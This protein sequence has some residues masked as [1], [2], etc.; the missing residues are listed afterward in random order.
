MTTCQDN[1][2]R[3]WDCWSN[4]NLDKLDREIVHSHNF[5]RYMTPFR[6]DRDLKDSTERLAIIGR[7]IYEDFSGVPLHPV[8]L[9]DTGTGGSVAELLDP[10]LTTI[11]P[12]NKIHP[13][14]DIII[15]GSSR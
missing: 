8:D 11:C 3:I 2:L 12:L 14:L 1:R 7:Y 10:N 4:G 9:I 15:T 5:N 6:A 13:R